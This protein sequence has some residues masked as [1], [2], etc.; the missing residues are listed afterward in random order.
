MKRSYLIDSNVLIYALDEESEFNEIALTVIAEG[1][2][3]EFTAYIS[4]QNLDET[5]AVI[6]NPKRVNSPLSAEDALKAIKE[7][8]LDNPALTIINPKAN[9]VSKVFE[10]SREHLPI[11][12]EIFDIVLIATMLDNKVTG[13]ITNNIEH[14][15]R[16]E[17][18]EVID[19]DEYLQEFQI[20]SVIKK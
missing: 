3:G 18:L 4:S 10:L 20:G 6:T 17:F 15:K 7:N 13:I 9:T 8:F 19:L 5:F 12:Q 14:F 2:K 11:R 16:F 1:E